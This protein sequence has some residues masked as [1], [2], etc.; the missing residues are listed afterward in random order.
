MGIK[1][2]P[3]KIIYLCPPFLQDSAKCAPERHKYFLPTTACKLKYLPP[4]TAL[5]PGSWSS[6]L[7]N[8]SS[9]SYCKYYV[10]AQVP[11]TCIMSY[12]RVQL[13]TASIDF[14]VLPT[15]SSSNNKPQSIQTVLFTLHALRQCKL[16]YCTG[17]HSQIPLYHSPTLASIPIKHLP[18]IEHTP[19]LC[20]L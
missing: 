5:I 14:R 20:F 6:Y 10:K 11:L 1:T 12:L 2:Q 9:G 19:C 15:S 13:L 17:P 16:G 4:P 8:T 3:R 7:L 18:G